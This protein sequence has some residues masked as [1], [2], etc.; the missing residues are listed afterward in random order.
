MVIIITISMVSLFS[1]SSCKTTAVATTEVATTEAATTEAATTEAAE[2]PATKALRIHF[3]TGDKLS[4]W[5]TTAWAGAEKAAKEDGNTTI[6]HNASETGAVDENVSIAEQAIAA[7]YDGIIMMTNAAEAYEEPLKKAKAAGIPSV[8]F[9]RA[10]L[11]DTV[12]VG[13][14]GPDA[15]AYAS[16][17]AV[18]LGTK[19]GGKGIVLVEQA[20]TSDKDKGI[21]E[22]FNNKMKEQYPDIKVLQENCSLDPAVLISKVTSVIQKNPGI[23]G[24]W[25]CSASYA[26]LTAKVCEDQGI[27]NK[28]TILGNA[29]LKT[30]LDELKLGRIQGIIDEGNYTAGYICVKMLINYIRTGKTGYDF[31][32]IIPTSIVESS[33]VGDYQTIIDETAALLESRGLL[34]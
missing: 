30:N 4:E 16:N 18:W 9:F 27:L 24:F 13:Y 21:F 6:T 1:L 34:K 8:A 3:Q 33:N 28:V 26:V 10:P 17:A 19:M 22:E 29:V 11:K 23:N 2:T 20:G 12:A 14:A 15:L 32:Y 7:K 25:G 31:A 5:A